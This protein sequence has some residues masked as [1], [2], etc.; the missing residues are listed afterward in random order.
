M[1]YSIG[2]LAYNHEKYILELL[3]SIKYQIVNYGEGIEIFLYLSD[4]ASKDRTVAI[5]TTWIKENSELF[6]EYEI[7][8]TSENKGTTN[9]YYN[10]LTRIK[11]EFFKVIAGDDVFAQN[12][13]FEDLKTGKAGIAIAHIPLLLREGILE[14][15]IH[16]LYRNL[17]Y[18]NT[19][20]TH[21]KEIRK[22]RYGGYVSTPSF[23][24]TRSLIN[25]QCID[26]MR[27][28]I[29]FEDDP[30]WYIMLMTNE[31][32]RVSFDTKIKVLY[33][34]HIGSVSNSVS[35]DKK[36]YDD[37]VKMKEQYLCDSKSIFL[38]IYISLYLSDLNYRY[39]HKKKRQYTL[40]NLI[41]KVRR[42]M[43]RIYAKKYLSQELMTSLQ[44]ECR[45]N[46]EYY[47]KIHDVAKLKYDEIVKRLI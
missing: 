47:D 29:V 44:D 45:A 26:F 37:V 25:S 14:L 42:E 4:D 43:V 46:Q 11:T 35:I 7:I 16:F 17:I 15:P 33:R 6:Q 10:L 8:T 9:S 40:F 23:F 28:F 31:D 20:R 36:W 24:P 2:I 12:D 39:I 19:I 5:V 13:I 34:I 3:E 38:H 41:E 22:F 21:E 30:T 18:Q 1:Q 32:L 27:Q